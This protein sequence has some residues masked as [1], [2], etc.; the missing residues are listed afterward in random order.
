LAERAHPEDP[1]FQ[2]KCFGLVRNKY[3]KKMYE[4]YRFCHPYIRDKVLLDIPCGVGWGTSLLKGYKSMIGMDIAPDAINYANSHYANSRLHFLAGNMKAIPVEDNSFDNI[5]CLEGFEHISKEIGRTFLTEVKRVL[6]RNGL[7]IMTCPV[8]SEKGET[9][10]N[11]Y[12]LSEYSEEEFIDLMNHNFRIE[13]LNRFQGP[14]GIEYKIVVENF[15][16]Q[17]YL[18]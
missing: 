18:K 11:P 12:H 3:K 6:R 17:R 14:D 2:D 8:L 5:I 1:G 7:L 10:G 9:T 16:E 15:K 13:Q 4:R